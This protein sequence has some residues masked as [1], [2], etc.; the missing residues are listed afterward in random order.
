MAL[1]YRPNDIEIRECLI[2]NYRGRFIDI[3]EILLEFSMFHDL[4]DTNGIHCE[5]V[6]ADS[7]GL[8]EMLPVV[9]DETLVITFRT[10]SFQ[11][12]RQYIFRVYKVG[13]RAKIEQRGDAYVIY[14]ASLETINNHRSSVNKSFS[15]LNGS[16]IVTSV[17]ENQLIARAADHQAV[18]RNKTLT[19]EET[20]NSI[21]LVV[22]GEKPFEVINQVSRESQSKS[23]PKIT[24][25][26]YD[27]EGNRT[28]V[29]EPVEID[30]PTLS[31]N[32][33]FYED[34]NGWNF[35]TIDSLMNRVYPDP[36]NEGNTRDYI[37]D[38]YLVD[39]SLEAKPKDG[40]KIND[41]QKIT[42]VDFVKQ[43]DS[44]ENLADGFYY[45][46][47]ETIDPILKTFKTENFNY[48]DDYKD[49][50]HLEKKLSHVGTNGKQHMFSADS[51]FAS[52]SG[53]AKTHYVISDLADSYD[54]FSIETD[55]QLSNPR[56]IQEF[57]KYDWVSRL[58]LNNIV[59]SITIPGNTNIDVGQTVQLHLPQTSQIPDFMTKLN[60]LYGKK[61]FVT[62][63]R[64]TLN[65][66]DNTFFTIM[67][68]VKD[69]YARE[70]IEETTE[71]IEDE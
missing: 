60:L 63:V 59:L 2:L 11:N 23:R 46:K 24:T 68:C 12:F 13:D 36:K 29:E 27:I 7:N 10:P 8:V 19:V 40:P 3:R 14:G 47:V 39:A 49:I 38:F 56:K 9:G 70:V 21:N 61:F 30:L 26:N 43:F 41:S 34:Y 35:R 53:T 62:A 64:H 57:I 1:P 17:Y 28:S 20:S 66:D 31:S 25:I 71:T 51:I 16:D 18:R 67:E 65:K 33:V 5:I 37:E 54:K 55:N 22:P 4:M 44:L 45:H 15:G 32:F 58:Q 48:N 6:F 69:T 50:N 42:K 52:D